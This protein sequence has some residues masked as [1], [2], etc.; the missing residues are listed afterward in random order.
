MSKIAW[1]Q[2]INPNSATNALENA[3]A[4]GR[5]GH[6]LLLVASDFSL[7]D[8]VACV[9]AESLL[10]A[11]VP[12]ADYLKVSPANKQHQ[13]GVDPMREMREFL[14]K[15]SFSGVKVAHIS[16][17]DRLNSTAANLFLK[18]LEEPPVGATIILT[19]SEP[20]AVLPT[21]LSRVMRFRFSSMSHVERG[22]IFSSWAQ[23]LKDALLLGS[24]KS[25]FDTYSFIDEAHRILEREGEKEEKALAA[26]IE[27]NTSGEVME[28]LIASR[29]KALKKSLFAALEGVVLDVFKTHPTE[30]FYL[31]HSLKNVE[32]IYRMLGV[33]LNTAA[34]LESAIGECFC[35][36]KE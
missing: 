23:R 30:S 35:L 4:Q 5:L 9:L 10:G 17:A 20:Y 19:T 32:K 3:L 21:L 8:K 25:I 16:Q 13:I 22:A 14:Q 36:A 28:A 15:G 18:I 24:P 12:H 34:A 1:P 11:G 2:S 29:Q 7:A 27:E 33:N 6:G 31:G 26:S